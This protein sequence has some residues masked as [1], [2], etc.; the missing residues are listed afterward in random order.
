[1]KKTSSR[2][3]A[4]GDQIRDSVME[5]LLTKVSDPRLKWLS[6]TEVI[7]SKDLSHANLYFSSFNS[8]I[9]TADLIKVLFRTKGFI[10]YHLSNNLKLRRIPKLDFIYDDSFEKGESIDRKLKDLT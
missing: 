2:I 9:T 4:V 8:S 10:R 7:L 6:I 3:N 1:M 5:V